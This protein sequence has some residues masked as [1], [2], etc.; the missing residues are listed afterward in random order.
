MIKSHEDSRILNQIGQE[1][2]ST[3]DFETVFERLYQNVNKLMDAT[4]FGVRLFDA[5]KNTVEYLYEYEKGHRL[6]PLSVSMNNKDN[7]SVWC[8]EN[9]KEI[10]IHNNE[11]DY[12]KYVSK[13]MVVGGD[14]PYSLIFYPLRK[15]DKVLGAISVQSFEKNAYSEY[16]L[17]IVKT[18]AHYA[19]IALE[20]A[21][22]YELMEEA[23]RERT[24]EL[25]SQKEEVLRSYENT[26]LISEI[27]RDI[28]SELSVEK[29]NALVYSRINQLMPAEGFGIGIY[30]ERVN[31]LFYP[32]YIELD[33]IL[34]ECYDD[35]E[36]E[37]MIA[38]YCFQCE[39][40]I[41][42]GNL[43]TEYS[44]YIKKYSAP[45]HGKAVSSLIYLP[46]K[47]KGRKIGVITVQSFSENAYT[48]YHVNILRSLAV[49]T[50]IALDNAGLYQNM[51][52][53]VVLRT[54]EIDRAYQNTKLI[55]QISRDITESLSVEKIIDKVYSNI[56]AVMDATCFGIGIY[57][58][59]TQMINMP[60]FIENGERMDLFGY[61]ITDDRLATWCFNNKKEIFISNYFE[62]YHHYI[63]GIQKPVSGKDS[64]SII[65]LP[66]CLKDEIVG[67]ITVQSFKI[68]AYTEYEL[69]ILRGLANTIAAAIENAKL[70]ESLEDK[71]RE[72]TAEVVK[73]KE[74]IEEKNKNITDSIIYAKRIQDATL[75]AKELVKSYLENS[76]VL[77]KPKDIVS[78]DFY[79]I[80][81]VQNLIL[82]AVVDC[83]GHGVP[84]AFLSLIGHNSLNQIVN[85]LKIYQPNKILEELNR[86]V[87]KTLHNSIEHGTNIKDGMDMAI[88]SLNLDTNE[89]QFAGAF[90]PLYLVRNGEMEEIKGDKFPIGAGFS[91][92]PEFTNNHIQLH[93]GDC[94][95][96]FSDG[97]ADQFGGPKGKKFKYSRFKEI[98]VEIHQKEMPEQHD[99]L[100]ALIEEWQG[101]LEQ[102]DDV[103]VIGIKP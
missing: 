57:D 60:G 54:A 91:Q 72:R 65:Y 1:L 16:H 47:V 50:A 74:I 45:V 73:Q 9:D 35:L 42:V 87:S 32:G 27:G 85:E 22:N 88:C 59:Q 68:N 103:C 58:S 61:H 4:I 34:E 71:V 2:I 69:D 92:N 19:V 67:L 43:N 31:K 21:R 70:Y 52:E 80:E 11:T 3:L 12:Q 48:E 78:G 75:P 25:V 10:L 29:I 79:W 51:E 49:Y 76:F 64:L 82:F 28:T 23:V 97:Y 8:I 39:E 33:E 40:E 100:N 90:N 101:D 55:G 37:N 66:L 41:V 63:K 96:L 30:D 24:A 94:I 98:L 102:I 56:N 36:D 81:R 53:R 15:G 6:E 7:Y 14:F 13:V 62:E 17:N 89:L 95:Y 18:L 84:G 20:N 44:K 86:I 46:L 77:F 5:E 93:E 83:T 99:I 26:K 38:G